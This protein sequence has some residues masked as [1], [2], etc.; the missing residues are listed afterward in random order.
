M[1]NFKHSST[2][3]QAMTE[4]SLKAKLSAEFIGTFFLC[5]AIN[6]TAIHG[7]VSEY[8]PY[9]IAF[10]LMSM[11]Y[12]TSFISGAHFNPVVTLALWLRGACQGKEVLPYIMTQMTAGVFA[13]TLSGH[14][15]MV[16]TTTVELVI[17]ALPAF[18]AELFFTFALVS[19]ILGVATV[20]ATSDNVYFGAAIS[21][22][23]LVGALSVGDI[24]WASFN[25]AVTGALVISGA[26]KM[27]DSWVHIVPQIIGSLSAVYLF[28]EIK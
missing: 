15:M 2:M 27:G 4:Y 6:I 22:V 25:P 24:S 9:V 7:I 1:A 23:V 19:V 14:L 8:A 13:S 26:M 3:R 16:Q 21:L 10:V 11:I 17:E 18:S 28:R 12:T 20:E 5:F